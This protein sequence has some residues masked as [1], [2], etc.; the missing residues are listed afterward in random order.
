[1]R[2]IGPAMTWLDLVVGFLEVATAALT[3]MVKTTPVAV[4]QCSTALPSPGYGCRTH[5]HCGPLQKHVVFCVCSLRG[6]MRSLR[7]EDER[8]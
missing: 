8:N 2:V 4:G 7:C 1:M 3:E 6:E 5:P